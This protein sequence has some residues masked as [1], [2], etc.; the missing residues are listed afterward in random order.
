MLHC[1]MHLD[2]MKLKPSVI[3]LRSFSCAGVCAN[4]T[5]KIEIGW[6]YVAYEVKQLPDLVSMPWS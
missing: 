1:V 3:K 2:L 6:N 4:K 5:L